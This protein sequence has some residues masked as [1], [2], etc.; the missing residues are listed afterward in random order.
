MSQ[1]T[2]DFR[3]VIILLAQEM[4]ARLKKYKAYSFFRNITK[5]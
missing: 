1:K 2:F 5:L 4:H 3:K